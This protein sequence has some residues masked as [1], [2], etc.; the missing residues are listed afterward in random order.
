MLVAAGPAIVPAVNVDDFI[1][2]GFWSQLVF[3][4][5]VDWGTVHAFLR[6]PT[7]WYHWLAFG[8]LNLA[9]LF[10]TWKIWAWLKHE[11]TPDETPYHTK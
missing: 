10:A 1:K 3:L 11:R 7:P 6:E 4:A 5:L 2:L 9:L 8:V